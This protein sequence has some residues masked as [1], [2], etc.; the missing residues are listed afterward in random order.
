MVYI[1]TNHAIVKVNMLFYEIKYLYGVFSYFFQKL[2]FYSYKYLLFFRIQK[3]IVNIQLRAM[4]FKLN[5]T[6]KALVS[7]Y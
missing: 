7:M 2:K 6:Q 5:T 1:S 4:L 3:T